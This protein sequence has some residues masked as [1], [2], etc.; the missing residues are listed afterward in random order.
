MKYK[1]LIGKLQSG[2][3]TTAIK[4]FKD[5]LQE[6]D[7]L[8]I[9]ATHP[10]NNVYSD[11]V[12]KFKLAK[13][14]ANLVN[15]RDNST[16]FKK[17]LNILLRNGTIPN[18]FGIVGLNNISFHRTIGSAIL[19]YHGKK[20][21]IVDE[22]DMNQIEFT[23]NWQ[24]V[25]RDYA[26][27]SYAVE[28]V[29]D[30]MILL[31]ATNLAA[32]IS[33][34][35]FN[36]EDITPIKPG[37]G[38]NMKIDW[39]TIGDREINALRA[40]RDRGF[41]QDIVDETEHNVMINVDTRKETH[42]SI[43]DAL[44][45]NNS[46]HIVNSDEEFNF[47]DLQ[48]DKNV[49]IGGAMFARGQTFPRIQ[50]L[51][52]DKPSANQAT[53]LQAVGRLFGYKE[54]PLRIVCTAEQREMIKEGLELEEQIS[55][56]NILSLHPKLRHEWIK[57]QLESPKN[58]KVFGPKNGGWRQRIIDD[59]AVEKP[60]KIVP[61]DKKYYSMPEFVTMLQ[62]RVDGTPP[63]RGK[64][65]NYFGTTKWGNRSVEKFI[66][67]FVNQH[68]QGKTL[69]ELN[70]KGELRRKQI[71]PPLFETWSSDG[72]TEYEYE[73]VDRV[74]HKIDDLKD[75][76][77]IDNGYADIDIRQQC[78]SDYVG[79]ILNTG[80]IALWKNLNTLPEDRSKGVFDNDL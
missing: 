14:D 13:I 17:F 72:V 22:Y 32:A 34:L 48:Q 76:F 52:I 80:E 67:D 75:H 56:K 27:R 77:Y 47:E 51:I 44:C 7:C 19:H 69:S 41:I 73:Q 16:E 40:G 6:E 50:T 39:D 18:N 8:P 63:P 21:M 68:P 23:R 66:S 70:E 33:D 12:S 20:S 4:I 25:K 2:K 58:L 59:W 79:S 54:Y 9:F 74:I 26:L 43:A 45:Y 62:K 35:S 64:D 28:D 78:D 24:P 10:T 3:T 53:L 15:P 42:G 71:V 11:L 60:H 61:Y 37:E 65:G 30:E 57:E 38:Y 49:V 46:C 5:L 55:D 1:L 31:S 36:S 29:L